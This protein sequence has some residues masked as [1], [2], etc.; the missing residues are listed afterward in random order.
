LFTTRFG[1]PCAKPALASQAHGVPLY[2][3]YVRGGPGGFHESG[4]PAEPLPSTHARSRTA[5]D[6]RRH[7]WR[8]D[9]RAWP[10]GGLQRVVP[11]PS[12]MEGASQDGLVPDGLHPPCSRQGGE[13]DGTLREE[14]GGATLEGLGLRKKTTTRTRT[15]TR[16]RTRRDT[17]H[18]HCYNYRPTLP[19]T[20][21]PTRPP[22]HLRASTLVAPRPPIATCV[23]ARWWLSSY[24]PHARH[25]THTTTTH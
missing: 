3:G 2:P 5:P 12:V 11:T 8:R 23:Q 13:L 15:E 16:T 22:C 9:E 24:P 4:A 14:Q 20:L 7:R 19:P 10:C 6:I 25:T 1:A 21:P 17:R 18:T